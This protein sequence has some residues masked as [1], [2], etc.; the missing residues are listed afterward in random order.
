MRG[1]PERE[2][3][4]KKKQVFLPF[5]FRISSLGHLAIVAITNLLHSAP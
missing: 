3:K 5:I 1:T 2:K 4:V